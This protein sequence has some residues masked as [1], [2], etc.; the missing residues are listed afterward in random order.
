MNNT[1]KFFKICKRE[2]FNR[3]YIGFSIN[4]TSKYMDQYIKKVLSITFQF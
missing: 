1:D 2:L 4:I 3:N